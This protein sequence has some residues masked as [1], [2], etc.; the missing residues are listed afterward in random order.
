MKKN[1]FVLLS[2]IASLTTSFAQESQS[3]VSVLGGVTE[4]DGFGGMVGYA[5][6]VGKNSY[7]IVASH[8]IFKD[9]QFDEIDYS[10]SSLQLGY[11]RDLIRNNKNSIIIN[12]GGGIQAGYELIGK[13]ENQDITINSKNDFVYGLYAD[14]QIDVFLSDRIS[15]ILR[16]Q[17][18]YLI[19]TSTGKLNPFFGG[20]FKINL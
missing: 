20:G 11:M 5:Y 2:L 15:F 9:H 16:A 17:E 13:T 14:I 19:T 6:S 18:N 10:V 12:G 3:S 4:K 7:E 1:V 8:S